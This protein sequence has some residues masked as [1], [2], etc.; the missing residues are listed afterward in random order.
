MVVEP[1]KQN[2]VRSQPEEVIDRLALFAK[3]VQLGMELDINLT[4]QASPDDLPNQAEDQMLPSLLDI[5][6]TDVDNRAS[7]SL[8]GCDD[9]VVVLGHLE[10]I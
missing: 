5:R 8:R 10:S 7:N 1:P 3:T 2:L 4:E 9:N 6:G